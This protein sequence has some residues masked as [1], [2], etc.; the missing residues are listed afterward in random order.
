MAGFH[1]ATMAGVREARAPIARTIPVTDARRAPA[2]RASGAASLILV[3]APV[4]AAAV[5]AFAAGGCGGALDLSSRWLDREVTVDGDG[6]DWQG[7]TTYFEKQKLSVGV[8]NDDEFLYLAVFVG[9]SSDEAQVL[10]RG[11]TVW[12]D[13]S[14]GEEEVLGIHYPLGLAFDDPSRSTDQRRGQRPGQEAA[15]RQGAPDADSLKKVL[16][17]Q[18]K[19]LEIYGPEPG[20]FHAQGL[21]DNGVEVALRV[22]ETSLVYEIKI[23]LAKEDGLPFGIGTEPGDK[24][25]VGLETPEVTLPKHGDG[26]G[27]RPEGM[28]GGRGGMPGG[29]PPP[30][31]MP[32][33]G[34]PPG[35]MGGGRGGPGG[36]QRPEPPEPLNVWATVKLAPPPSR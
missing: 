16:A 18:P 30:G 24:I 7:A 3:A 22:H 8:L 13:P 35:G 1:V 19:T 36:G 14:G 4:L 6:S 11:C 10:L 33:G 26:T 15:M 12:F 2:L 29:A 27:R 31:G 23:P 32:G 21:S 20:E 5:L 17:R 9:D 25:G 34:P 28:G